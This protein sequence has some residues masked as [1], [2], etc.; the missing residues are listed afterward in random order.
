MLRREDCLVCEKVRG[1]EGRVVGRK[2]ALHSVSHPQG[3]LG[4][5]PQL[6]GDDAA[7]MHG[8]LRTSFPSPTSLW[9]ISYFLQHF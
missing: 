8:A 3:R 6:H 5:C 9:P 2:G 1:R 4:T 7:R